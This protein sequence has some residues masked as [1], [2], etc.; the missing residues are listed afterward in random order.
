MN[1]ERELPSI[2]DQL[3]LGSK[4]I[5]CQI[6]QELWS[7]YGVLARVKT[8]TRDF[9][10]KQISYPTHVQHPK[11]HDS[12]FAHKRK[13]KSYKVEM[14]FYAHY[15]QHRNLAH[16]PKYI[17]H[18]VG[19]NHFLILEDLQSLGFQPKKTITESEAV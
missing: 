16:T 13:E 14:N 10:I 15:T 9:V 8:D 4:V 5:N 7:G 12:E 19:A 11:G 6:I 17:A 2:I 18:E 3:N 1:F